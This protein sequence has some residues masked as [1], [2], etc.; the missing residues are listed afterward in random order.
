MLGRVPAFAGMTVLGKTV[1]TNRD[2]SKTDF[3]W[4]SEIEKWICVKSFKIL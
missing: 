2:I 4:Q 3:R 1:V